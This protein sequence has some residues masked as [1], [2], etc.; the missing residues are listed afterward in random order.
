MTLAIL[1]MKA[2][3]SDEPSTAPWADEV[4]S[5]LI[6]LVLMSAKQYLNEELLPGYVWGGGH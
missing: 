6:G 3:P 5:L 2:Q 4:T 1:Q